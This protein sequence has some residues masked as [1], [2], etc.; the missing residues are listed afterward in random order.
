MNKHYNHLSQGERDQI[1]VFRAQGKSYQEIAD[2][3]GRDKST[4]FREY[5]R[6]KSPAYD[7]YLPHKAQ[8]RAG[9]RKSQ[10]HQ[11]PRL[12]D[13]VIRN[14]V[15]RKLKQDWSPEQIANRLTKE[16]PGQAISYEAIYQYIYDPKIRQ[17][18]DLV[19][20]LARLHKKRK[21]KG[22]GKRHKTSHIPNRTSITERPREVA[23]RQVAGHWEGDTVTSRKSLTALAVAGER[24]S[25]LIKIGKLKR[26]SAPEL[27]KALN[28]RL[29]RYPQH[30]RQSIT[31]DNGSE[32]V[33]H[34]LVNQ[35]LGT[36]SYFCAPYHAW[37]K[38]GVENLIGLIR[39][40][41][42]KGT[43]LAKVSVTELKS[44][45]SKLNNR[46]RKCLGYQTPLE[47]FKSNF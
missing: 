10:A 46:P 41:L 25:R 24:C 27:R 44:I 30:L 37:E 29:S 7:V 23:A 47:V 12:K 32:N 22:Q 39:R 18:E 5:R 34:E 13:N 26:K 19:P 33:E 17:K 9:E 43:D 21:Y 15:R 45:E 4:V 31:Y 42:P 1:A 6:N 8:T 16:Y 2:Q 3:L 14:Y 28:R 35:V 20:H 11:R 40:Y 36:T 38:G